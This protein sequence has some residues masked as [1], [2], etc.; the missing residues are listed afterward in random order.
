MVNVKRNVSTSKEVH[1]EFLLP[2]A[3]LFGGAL[4]VLIYIRNLKLTKRISEALSFS[5]G[6]TSTYTLPQICVTQIIGR[7]LGKLSIP[8]SKKS[9]RTNFS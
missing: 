5:K 9:N 6:S 2:N 4:P 1:A 3:T 8:T 7:L